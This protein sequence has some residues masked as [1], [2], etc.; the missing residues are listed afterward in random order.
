MP[1][2]WG[3]ERERESQRGGVAGWVRELC[4]LGPVMGYFKGLLT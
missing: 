2:R 1:W 4:S 3:R